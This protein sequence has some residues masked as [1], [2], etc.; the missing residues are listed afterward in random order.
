MTDEITDLQK[1]ADAARLALARS[2]AAKE[3]AERI[4]EEGMATLKAEFGLDSL[5]D[6]RAKLEALRTELRNEIDE[7]VNLLD[8]IE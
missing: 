7:V 8:K 6:A 1:R 5:E 3:Q 2:Q 4:Y